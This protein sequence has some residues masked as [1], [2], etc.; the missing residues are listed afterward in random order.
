MVFVDWNGRE[1]SFKVAPQA[2]EAAERGR[3][4]RERTPASTQVLPRCRWEKNTCVIPFERGL[5]HIDTQ[6]FTITYEANADSAR[7]VEYAKKNKADVLGWKDDLL[8]LF[9]EAPDAAAPPAT[10]AAGVDR[11]TPDRPIDVEML[12]GMD[13][14]TGKAAKKVKVVRA[15]AID[16]AVLSPNGQYL[17]LR[18]VADGPEGSR[19]RRVVIDAKGKVVLDAAEKTAV[20]RA[21]VEDAPPA[22]PPAPPPPKPGAPAPPEA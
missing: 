9:R 5:L 15:D 14:A 10:H 16:N 6:K 22:P 18:A 17:F 19:I 8:V 3:R 2:T 20:K 21:S 7:Q 12:M 4:E 11:P 1:H 13:L